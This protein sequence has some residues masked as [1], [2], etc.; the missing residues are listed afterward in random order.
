MPAPV[1]SVNTMWMVG[2]VGPLGSE[3]SAH[4]LMPGSAA[5]TSATLACMPSTQAP[6]PRMET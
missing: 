3:G 4:T 6:K 2:G 5:R 1:R